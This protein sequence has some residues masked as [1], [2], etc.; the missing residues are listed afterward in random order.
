M[1]M[2]TRAKIGWGGRARRPDTERQQPGLPQKGAK[3]A[4]ALTRISLIFTD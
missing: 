4:G 3:G 2:E 1:M